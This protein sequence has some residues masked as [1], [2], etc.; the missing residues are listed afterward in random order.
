MGG[1]QDVYNGTKMVVKVL[2]DCGALKGICQD[3]VEE[4]DSE[5]STR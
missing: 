5:G 4:L 1:R 2:T 3:S